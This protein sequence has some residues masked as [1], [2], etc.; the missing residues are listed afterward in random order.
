[1]Y[2]CCNRCDV[3][4]VQRSSLWPPYKSALLVLNYFYLDCRVC[5]NTGLLSEI[6]AAQAS[7]SWYVVVGAPLLLHEAMAQG[8]QC[9]HAGCVGRCINELLRSSWAYGGVPCWDVCV[10]QGGQTGECRLAVSTWLRG[11]CSSGCGGAVCA[12][13]VSPWQLPSSEAPVCA[14]LINSFRIMC[15]YSKC[16]VNSSTWG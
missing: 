6:R 12:P 9:G 1:M 7:L 2:C 15:A 8:V 10:S 14:L 4:V 3:L 5:F 13:C 16:C 11:S